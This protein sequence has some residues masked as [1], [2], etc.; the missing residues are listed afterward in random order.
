MLYGSGTTS[1]Q[2]VSEDIMADDKKIEAN[3]AL[4]REYIEKV[5]NDHRPELAIDYVTPDVTWHGGTLGTV[6]GAENLTGLLTAFIGG[7]DGLYAAEQDIIANEDTV[8]VRLVVTATHSSDLLGIPKTGL[9]IRWDAIDVYRIQD[10]KISE[11]WAAD[12]LAAF[13]D[14]L[15]VARLPWKA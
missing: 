1:Q 7:L 2:P 6:E 5:F 8:V 10:G 13:I 4:A 9:P 12:D 11:E 15:N 14:Q 3:I